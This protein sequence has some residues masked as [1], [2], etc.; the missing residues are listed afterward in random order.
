[1]A[2]ENNSS[3]QPGSIEL[4]VTQSPVEEQDKQQPQQFVQQK[5]GELVDQARNQIKSQIVDRKE[6][7]AGSL[8]SVSQALLQTGEQ[9]RQGE[10]GT[11][12]EYAEMA[13]EQVK[14]LA[15]YLHNRDLDQLVGEVEN[16]ARGR[17]T[18]FLASAF[19]VGFV[20]SRFLKSSP[21]SGSNFGEPRRSYDA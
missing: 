15:A 8:D 4:G 7:V 11:V 12:G 6:A 17:S 5:A 18:L 10:Q 14:Q 16:F 21:G 9:L 20:A 1:M 3:G 13:A 2:V 19:A